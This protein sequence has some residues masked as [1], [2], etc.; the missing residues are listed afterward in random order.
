MNQSIELLREIM[1]AARDGDEGIRLLMDK[2][3]DTALREALMSE[4]EQ[5]QAVERD[6]GRKMLSLGGKAEPWRTRL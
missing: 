5:Y 2:T 6:A 4:Q 1:R 3:D